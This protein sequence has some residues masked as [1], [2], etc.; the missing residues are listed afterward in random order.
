VRLWDL[1]PLAISKFDWSQTNYYLL[2]DFEPEQDRVRT[3][4][5]QSL[6]ISRNTIAYLRM[7]FILFYFNVE[8]WDL[9][10]LTI[11]KFGWSQ[12][13]YYLLHDF[14][15]QQIRVRSEFE[16][17]EEHHCLLE[18][19]Y[20]LILF[21][22]GLSKFGWSQS[23]YS[24]LLATWIHLNWLIHCVWNTSQSEYFVTL[25]IQN[26]LHPELFMFGTLCTWNTLHLNNLHSKHFAS[27]T[28]SV[29]NTLHLEQFTF[30]TLHIWN[31][32]H[33]EQ[34]ASRTNNSCLEHFTSG[35]LLLLYKFYIIFWIC[36][37]F[38][39]FIKFCD[40][41]QI[42]WFYMIFVI[43]SDF[44]WF[45][46]LFCDYLIFILFCDYILFL[47][48]YLILY[49]LSDFILFLWFYFIFVILFYFCDF[50]VFLWF[51]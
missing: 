49:Y 29:W 12:T 48:F 6:N 37:I 9:R 19:V 46:L 51:I 50:I 28:I 11:S 14:E 35:T 41:I 2:H 43:L 17:L 22:E 30:G 5:G 34:F 36:F 39:I 24:L 42:L 40:F 47:R 13:N 1:W 33:L 21:I 18:N 16:H 31:S 8:L 20:Y 27:G 23:N 32:L 38:V 26:T 3:E 10:P 15:P 45:Y 44:I 4:W 7:Y 25:C